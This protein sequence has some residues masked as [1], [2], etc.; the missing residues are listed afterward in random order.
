LKA[1]L[2]RCPVVIAATARL[3]DDALIAK[4]EAMPGQSIYDEP[5]RLAQPDEVWNYGR[6]DGVEKAV[7]LANVLRARHPG[8]AVRVDVA[9]DG[10]ELQGA[11]HTVRFSSAKGLRAMTWHCG[12]EV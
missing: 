6:G 3:S 9:A 10:A 12:S 1:A 11:G 4:V 7:L 2:E 8:E 5:G